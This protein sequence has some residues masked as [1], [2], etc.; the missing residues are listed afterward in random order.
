LSLPARSFSTTERKQ[1]VHGS[2][3][4]S[5]VSPRR[6]LM[7]GLTQETAGTLRGYRPERFSQ[8]QH[9]PAFL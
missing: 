2:Q 8:S 3:K 1:P 4:I 5:G 7:N 6:L 9:L